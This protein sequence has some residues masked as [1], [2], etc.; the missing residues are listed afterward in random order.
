MDMVKEKINNPETKKTFNKVLKGIGI[1]FLVVL[2]IDFASF[3]ICFTNDLG[4]FSENNTQCIVQ[5][6]VK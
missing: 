3:I 5:E 4:P 2:I 1:G 6:T